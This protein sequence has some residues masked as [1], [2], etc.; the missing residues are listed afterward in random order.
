M[1]I[2]A[3]KG[4]AIEIKNTAFRSPGGFALRRANRPSLFPAFALVGVIYDHVT[5]FIVNANLRSVSLNGMMRSTLPLE[6]KM[7]I[8]P[9]RKLARFA[10]N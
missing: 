10:R 5:R 9:E 2:L 7:R 8:S 3:W 1:Q 6:S 4:S